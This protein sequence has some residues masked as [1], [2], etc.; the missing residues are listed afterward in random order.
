MSE[1]NIPSIEST[2]PRMAVL[3][4]SDFNPKYPN[5]IPINP[6]ILPHIGIKAAKMLMTPKAA[7]IIAKNL[8]V[9]SSGSKLL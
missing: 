1:V 9:R 4:C 7:E 2:I 6:T 8:F 3:R 5:P